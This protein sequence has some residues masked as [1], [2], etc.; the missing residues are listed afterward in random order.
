MLSAAGPKPIMAIFLTD[1]GKKVAPGLDPAV[2]SALVA[3]VRKLR[4]NLPLPRSLLVEQFA[5][6][7]VSVLE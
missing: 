5:D 6:D 7:V 3:E 2:R 1:E 4:E